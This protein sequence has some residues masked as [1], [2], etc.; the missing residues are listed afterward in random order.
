[1]AREIFLLDYTRD[2]LATEH[3]AQLQDHVDML[4]RLGVGNI[5]HRSADGDLYRTGIKPLVFHD[6]T[7]AAKLDA[8]FMSWA[9]GTDDMYEA[10]IGP[11]VLPLPFVNDMQCNAHIVG[12]LALSLSRV[13]KQLEVGSTEHMVVVAQP[14]LN[15]EFLRVNPSGVARERFHVAPRSSVM[16]R[17]FIERIALNERLSTAFPPPPVHGA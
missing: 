17:Y 6:G 4:G 16:N 1:M 12:A 5:D 7:Q 13:G 8:A 10:G 2:A 9:L 11:E 3:A 15:A 14:E